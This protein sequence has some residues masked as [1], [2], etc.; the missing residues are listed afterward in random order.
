MR[1]Q[2]IIDGWNRFFFAP[3]SPLPICLF[4]ILYGTMVIATLVLLHGDWLSWYGTHSWVSL[5]TMRQVEPGA[6]LNLFTIIPQ[7][8]GYVQ[9]LF[10]VSLAAATFLTV[11]LFTRVSAATV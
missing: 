11:G 2:S 8:D 7:N 10:W 5:A 9:A 1:L 3:Q 6:R 4:R